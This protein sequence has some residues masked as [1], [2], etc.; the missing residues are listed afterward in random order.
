M[1]RVLHYADPYPSGFHVNHVTLWCVETTQVLF[2]LASPPEPAE[3]LREA[4]LVMLCRRGRFFGGGVARFHV[5]QGT[6]RLVIPPIY[7]P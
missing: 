5:H 7:K 2:R 3:F 1:R 4:A 6:K